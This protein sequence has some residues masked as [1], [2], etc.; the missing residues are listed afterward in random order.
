[1]LLNFVGL[2]G[3][4]TLTVCTVAV[5]KVEWVRIEKILVVILRENMLLQS[6]QKHALGGS[7]I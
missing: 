3:S 2:V 7:N 1:M 5:L 6:S 4:Q